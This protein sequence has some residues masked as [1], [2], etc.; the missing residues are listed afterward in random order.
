MH[1]LALM[2]PVLSHIGASPE[3]LSLLISRAPASAFRTALGSEHWRA[4]REQ[5][6]RANEY[7]HVFLVRYHADLSYLPPNSEHQELSFRFL[8]FYYIVPGKEDQMEQVLSERLALLQNVDI[9]FPYDVFVGDIGTERPVYFVVHRAR[10][11]VEFYSR[12]IQETQRLGEAG[13]TLEDTMQALLRRFESRGAVLRSDLSYVPQSSWPGARACDP[14]PQ[15]SRFAKGA[16][17]TSGGG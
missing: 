14:H 9:S 11:R 15:A 1:P 4:I 10:D 2:L 12:R 8:E 17:T 3:P 13:Q 5:Y 6:V 7:F 16:C